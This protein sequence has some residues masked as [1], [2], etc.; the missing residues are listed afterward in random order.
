MMI[1]RLSALGQF[2]GR[3][4][5]LSDVC[6]T[7]ANAGSD[8]K[9]LLTKT[10]LYSDRNLAHFVAEQT[11]EKFCIQ[12]R[13]LSDSRDGKNRGIKA[14]GGASGSGSADA[15]WNVRSRFLIFRIISEARPALLI[16]GKERR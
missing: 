5:R 14:G 11:P 16:A 10:F 9:V 7:S 2:N 6:V 4:E 12:R 15:S 3:T 13:I 8:C 1:L